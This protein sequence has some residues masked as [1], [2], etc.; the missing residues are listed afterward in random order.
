[1]RLLSD[2]RP[3]ISMGVPSLIKPQ[4]FASTQR[5]IRDS[6]VPN[7]NRETHAGLWISQQVADAAT[8]F[9][10]KTA[11]LLPGEPFIYSSSLGDLV[12]EFKT[13]QGSMTSIVSPAFTMLFAVIDGVPVERRVVKEGDVREEVRQLT[14]LLRMGRHGAVATTKRSS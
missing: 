8:V 7:Y 13:G 14:G 3:E 4:W 9:F 2:Y 1:M 11:D 12:A 5:R 6:V 10:Q